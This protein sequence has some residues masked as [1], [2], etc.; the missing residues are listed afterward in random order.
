MVWLDRWGS[1]QPQGADVADGNGAN[2]NGQWLV[3]EAEDF[4]RS[5]SKDQ[6]SERKAWLRISVVPDLAH[7]SI[8]AFQPIHCI[9]PRVQAK[10]SDRRHL[11]KKKSLS[12]AEMGVIVC[13]T[14]FAV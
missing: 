5:K 9:R 6:L 13:C 14:V 3:R 4:S 12:T 10:K 8:K 2:G 1:S 11:I 7:L